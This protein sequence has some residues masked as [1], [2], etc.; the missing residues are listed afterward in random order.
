MSDEIHPSDPRTDQAEVGRICRFEDLLTL[1]DPPTGA[2]CRR[3]GALSGELALVCG[4]DPPRARS[5]GLAAS[6]HDVG[7]LAIPDRVL[8]KE[9]PLSVAEEELLRRHPQAGHD[10]LAA[11]GTPLFELAA[12]IALRH[13]ERVDGSGYPDGLGAEEIPFAA[14]MVAVAD[15]FEALVSERTYSPALPAHQ[16]LEVMRQESGTHFD[17]HLLELFAADLGLVASGRPGTAEP[18]H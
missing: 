10:L 4:L 5:I 16:A 8:L 2:H 12:T 3:V 14:R 9:G 18:P 15:S 11:V 7:K 1:R 17:S 13:H 6:L